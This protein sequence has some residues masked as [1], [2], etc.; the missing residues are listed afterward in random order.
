MLYVQVDCA[1]VSLL[2]TGSPHTSMPI[3]THLFKPRPPGRGFF[4]FILNMKSDPNGMA[5]NRIAIESTVQAIIKAV[6]RLLY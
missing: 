6:K 2:M 5:H 1:G 3:A 4:M